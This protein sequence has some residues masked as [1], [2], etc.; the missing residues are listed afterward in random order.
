MGYARRTYLVPI[1][2][3]ESLSAL[4][5][6]NAVLR[7]R[8]LEDQRRVMAGQTAS[9]AERLSVERAYLGPL[10][11]HAPDVGLVR[12]VV[13]RSTGQVR[14]EANVYYYYRT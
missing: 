4:Q 11:E 12:E 6:L 5:A 3:V 8:C 9:I 2:Q 7:E 10:P 13:V 14:F 1:P